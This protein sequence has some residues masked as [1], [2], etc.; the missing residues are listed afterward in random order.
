[1]GLEGVAEEL[2]EAGARF[3]IYISAILTYSTFGISSKDHCHFDEAPSR[4]ND[5]PCGDVGLV[6]EICPALTPPGSALRWS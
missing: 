4:S 1:M 2:L 5:M 6:S 3:L